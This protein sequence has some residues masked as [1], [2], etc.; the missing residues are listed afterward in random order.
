MSLSIKD[1]DKYNQLQLLI[2]NRAEKVL[3]ELYKHKKWNFPNDFSLNRVDIS[4][5]ESVYI[6]YYGFMTNDS[7]VV[8][9]DYFLTLDP[10]TL[11][12]EGDK[13]E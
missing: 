1:L 5:L 9:I 12:K 13:I 3:K 7:E 2:E 8:P 10:K 6:F 11:D 4:E